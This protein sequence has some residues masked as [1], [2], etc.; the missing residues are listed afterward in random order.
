MV[1]LKSFE[2]ESLEILKDILCKN[3]G[4]WQILENYK[5]NYTCI[6]LAF[7]KNCLKIA[8]FLYS[9]PEFIEFY[10]NKPK[11]RNPFFL[12]LLA[13]LSAIQ[14]RD[15]FLKIRPPKKMIKPIEKRKSKELKFQKIKTN[16]IKFISQHRPLNFI[17]LFTNKEK[18][19]LNENY[20]AVFKKMEENLKFCCEN[21]LKYFSEP[22]EEDLEKNK[23][24]QEELEDILSQIKIFENK[25]NRF[26]CILIYLIDFLDIELVLFS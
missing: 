14:T 13:K 22:E 2:D 12:F 6:D 1:C 4:K 26:D 5:Q 21:C 23:K 7:E 10:L 18:K 15:P 25:K 19:E 20:S 8:D 16:E 17:Y 3:F 24:I 11:K 9:F